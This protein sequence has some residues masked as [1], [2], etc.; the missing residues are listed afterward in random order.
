MLAGRMQV[1]SA[2]CSSCP[3]MSFM[4]HS[5]GIFDKMVDS[6]NQI[7][8]SILPQP[9]S[10]TLYCHTCWQRIHSTDEL[11]QSEIADRGH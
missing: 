3:S 6:M 7:I 11:V 10:D 2:S 8:Y 5:H 4:H 1:R 9:K